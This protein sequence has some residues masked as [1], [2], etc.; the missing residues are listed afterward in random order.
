MRILLPVLLA[1]VA[2]P[3][4][5]L[6][7]VRWLSSP[8]ESGRHSLQGWLLRIPHFPTIFELNM[9]PRTCGCMYV[10]FFK[11]IRVTWAVHL[12]ISDVQSAR[13][14]MLRLRG[15]GWRLGCTGQQ[16]GPLANFSPPPHVKTYA[17][18]AGVKMPAGNDS[19]ERTIEI[20][21]TPDEVFRI[22][23]GFEDYPVRFLYE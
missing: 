5:C 19:V 8:P 18:K 12:H 2:L 17:E 10:F 4:T 22:A 14:T 1:V 9:F 7:S 20:D 21:A 13:G 23:V 6:S 11:K 3:A 16:R 15:G